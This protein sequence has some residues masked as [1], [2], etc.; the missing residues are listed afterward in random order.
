MPST[1]IRR[2]GR[3]SADALDEIMTIGPFRVRATCPND[4]QCI[5]GMAPDAEGPAFIHQVGRVRQRTRSL[6]LQKDA[7]G[8]MERWWALSLFTDLPWVVLLV[9]E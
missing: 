9:Q 1:C 4:A 8:A 3:I 5:A 6:R 7:P 2:V